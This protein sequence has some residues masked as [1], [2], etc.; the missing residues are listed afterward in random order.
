LTD[1]FGEEWSKISG[2]FGSHGSI[3]EKNYSIYLESNYFRIPKELTITFSDIEAIDKERSFIEFNFIEGSFET[4]IEN[5]PVQLTINEPN[6][7]MYTIENDFEK[8]YKQY[9][10]KLIDAKGIEF[11]SSTSTMSQNELGAE[12]S[13]MFD[14]DTPPTNPVRLYVNRFDQYLSGEAS[15]T[16]QIK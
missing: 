6:Y 5:I 3:Y 13:F 14:F 10:H 15:L 9:F 11:H 2:G 4:A 8:E 16:V 12:G 1:E 7:L